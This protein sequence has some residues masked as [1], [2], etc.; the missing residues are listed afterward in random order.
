MNYKA[1]YEE[2]MALTHHRLEKIG[3]ELEA[4]I[5]LQEQRK[6]DRKRR[7]QGKREEKK[8]SKKKKQPSATEPSH[9]AFSSA[10]TRASGSNEVHRQLAQQPSRT[11][12][13]QIAS[14]LRGIVHVWIDRS[15]LS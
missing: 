8:T 2:R 11:E 14:S 1:M 7:K 5:S 15:C 10:G 4:Q 6:E 9:T 3:L 12:P 13:S